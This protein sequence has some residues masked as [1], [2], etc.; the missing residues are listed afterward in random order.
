MKNFEEAVNEMKSD[1]EFIRPDGKN[2]LITSQ[3]NLCG[4]MCA[5][6][7]QKVFSDLTVLTISA[8]Q[9]RTLD[10]YDTFRYEAVMVVGVP[11]HSKKF[12]LRRNVVLID[13]HENN[14]NGLV[15]CSD[16]ACSAILYAKFLE[17]VIGSDFRGAKE[18]LDL[19]NDYEMWIRKDER[20]A[21]LEHLYRSICWDDFKKRFENYDVSKFT[22]DEM[23][24]WED[25]Q[26][27][28]DD[29]WDKM[30]MYVS[31]NAMVILEER[32]DPDVCERI[33]QKTKKIDAVIWVWYPSGGSMRVRAG[34]ENAIDCGKILNKLKLGGG[35]PRFGG[36]RVNEKYPSENSLS[37][38]VVAILGE[39][40]RIP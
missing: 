25:E 9:D 20:S 35:F 38:A 1:L 3:N 17:I 30:E 26:K 15:F 19:V 23:K 13:H 28:K 4:R 11:V 29:I 39:V 40:N 5:L 24:L 8:G 27:R 14:S 31:R 10:H 16:S 2:L 7:A 32:F 37:D 22:D 6:L 36:F 12:L 34:K 18:M 21:I 33:F